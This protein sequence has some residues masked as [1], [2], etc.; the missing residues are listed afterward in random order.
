MVFGGKV[1]ETDGA[2][3]IGV[4]EAEQVRP[5]APVAIS[6]SLRIVHND[7]QPL[8]TYMGEEPHFFY[9]NPASLAGPSQTVLF[10]NFTTRVSVLPMVAAVVVSPGYRVTPDD[11]EDMVL[12]LCMVCLVTAPGIEEAE[13]NSK[14]GFGRSIDLGG[15]IGPVLTTPDELDDFVQD[16]E[17]GRRYKLDAISRVNGV[18]R[19]RGN[20]ENLPW[21]FAETIS[22]AAQSCTVKEGDIVAMGPVVEAEE[23][24]FLSGGDEYQLTIEQLGTLKFRLAEDL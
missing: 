21:T 23:V 11:A 10:P 22:H 15:V 9:A 20:L 17:F 8:T 13:R 19:D 1:Y 14:G 3:A 5:L 7:F 6:P 18:E 4:Y 2:T 24:L 12:G 16:A